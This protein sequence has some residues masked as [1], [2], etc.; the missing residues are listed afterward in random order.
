GIETFALTPF[1]PGTVLGEYLGELL[2]FDSNTDP[3]VR[4]TRYYFEV[5]GN[6]SEPLAWI[7]AL[8]VG[9]WHR[10]I[11]HSCRLNAEYVVKRV[12]RANRIVVEVV[13]DIGVG[14]E[15]TVGYG[16]DYWR[17]MSAMELFCGC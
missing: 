16:R 17:S 15:V 9:S 8:R 3:A 2:P 1:P 13:K 5:I 12:G 4:D 11:N 14:E 6:V 7:D 10:F